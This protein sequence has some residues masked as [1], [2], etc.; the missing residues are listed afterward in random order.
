MPTK[1]KNKSKPANH[2]RLKLEYYRKLT[3]R[4]LA[5]KCYADYITCCSEVKGVEPE[6]FVE[7]W[8]SRTV[9]GLA[10][11]GKKTIWRDFLKLLV[12]MKKSRV[13]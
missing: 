10:S 11:T 6:S 2:D 1:K 13:T 9:V 5:Y 4:L 3:F 8:I 7:N 12:D